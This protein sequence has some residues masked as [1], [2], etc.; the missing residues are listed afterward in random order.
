M[1]IAALVDGCTALSCVISKKSTPLTAVFLNTATWPGLTPEITWHLSGSVVSQ[2]SSRRSVPALKKNGMS[3]GTSSA[4]VA[5]R[6]SDG[7]GIGAGKTSLPTFD[8]SP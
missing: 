7:V 1:R 2:H 5:W 6:G 8:Q 3:D 4:R